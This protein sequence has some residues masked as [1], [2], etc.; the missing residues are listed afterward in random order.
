MIRA[1]MTPGTQPQRVRRKMI[2]TDPH[3]LSITASGG[4]KMHR[5][6]RRRPI[7][8]LLFV[9]TKICNFNVLLQFLIVYDDLFRGVF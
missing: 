8:D 7:Y 9:K 2:R 1:P 6:T 3:P 4:K 5:R